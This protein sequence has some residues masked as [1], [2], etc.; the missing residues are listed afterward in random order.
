MRILKWDPIIAPPPPT[1][2]AGLYGGR[3]PTSPA[4]GPYPRQEHGI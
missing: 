3:M 2:Q 1:S 4:P